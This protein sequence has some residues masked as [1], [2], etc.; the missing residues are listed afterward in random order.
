[1]QDAISR[2]M[3]KIV[4]DNT[5]NFGGT[6]KLKIGII[7]KPL[8]GKSTLFS[9]LTNHEA[10]SNNKTQMAVGKIPDP[11]VDRIAQLQKPLK[12]VYSAIDFWDVPG[13]LPGK[14][15]VA[16]LQ[17]VRDVDALVVVIRAFES[18]TVPS[19]R[20]QALR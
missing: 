6:S 1:M 19:W 5:A 8:A 18:E 11:R 2:D 7:G 3:A 13:F 15:S 20:N 10:S 12:V 17:T 14:N 4:I 16:F 9:L